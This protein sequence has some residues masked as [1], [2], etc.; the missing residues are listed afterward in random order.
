MTTTAETFEFQT[1]AKQLLDLMIHSVY[2]HPEI[3]LRELISNASDALD[4]LRYEALTNT[5]LAPLTT[6][7]HIRITPDRAARTLSLEDNGIGMSRDEI[8]RFIGTIA[9]SGTKEY[10]KA[11]REAKTASDGKPLSPELI[12]QFGVGFYS[13][14]MVA[15]RVTL[16]TRRA[17]EAEA[18]KWESTGD[19]TYTLEPSERAEPGTTITL[20]LKPEDEE[21]GLSDFTREWTIR[22]TVRKYSDF[23]S[24][25]IRMKVER[26]ETERDEDGKPRKDAPETV[27]VEDITLNSMKAIWTRPSSEVT[28]EEYKDFYKHISHD[29]SDPLKWSTM[30]AE[31][32]AEFRALLYIPAKA[33]MDLFMRDG[34]RGIQLYIKRIF[35]MQDCKELIP[36]Y[37]RFVRGVV[38]SED[39][40]LNISREILQKNRQIQ[41]I[42]KGVIKKVLDTLRTLKNDSK[43]EFLKF[44]GEFGRVLKEGLFQDTSNREAIMDLCLFA[45]TNSASDLTTI[46]EYIGRMKEDQKSIYY[47]TG[48]SRPA[49]ENSPHLEAFRAKGYEVLLL[50]EPVDEVWVGQMFEHKG[51]GFQSVGK[52]TAEIGSEEER[53]KSEEE[54]KGR[55]AEFKPLFQALKERLDEQVKEVRLSARLTDSP[56][57]LVGDLYD[58]TPQM[59][60]L[61]KAAGQEV[62]TSKRI[63]ELNPA[64]PIVAKLKDLAATDVKDSRITDYAELLYGQSILAEGGQLPDP[65]AFSRKLADLMARGL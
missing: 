15:D 57:C 32:T 51:K 1:E 37:L 65:S 36:E 18:W 49:I 41:T 56:A 63:L 44:W 11:L 59:E 29:W 21:N 28:D 47:M 39:L 5:E 43:D 14:F 50:T 31:G 52:G 53:K 23:V 40:S 19:G 46:E 34:E 55:E 48:T 58:M 26:R 7:L 45:S 64:H 13:S 22:D 61:L 17:G 35:I 33:P 24:Y 27:T 62:P 30:H 6:D 10:L 3:F 2:S 25:P 42:R 54:L 16:L 9:K 4:K 60:A 8:V 20:H 38:D 12:G